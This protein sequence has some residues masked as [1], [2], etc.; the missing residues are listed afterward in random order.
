VTIGKVTK[1]LTLDKASEIKFTVAK[2]RR[3]ARKGGAGLPSDVQPGQALHDGA[4]RPGCTLRQHGEG[5]LPA[6]SSLR[7]AWTV[8]R[9]SQLF[10]SE[11]WTLRKYLGHASS[12]SRI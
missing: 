6:R 7:V 4:L 3:E 12:K 5:V 8:H 9:R 2:A 1:T 10:L 11:Y